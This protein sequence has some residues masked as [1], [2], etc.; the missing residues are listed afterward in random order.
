MKI[1]LIIFLLILHVNAFARLQATIITVS[2]TV[3]LA[4]TPEPIVATIIFSSNLFIQAK[5]A[6]TQ[7]AFVGP[8]SGSQNYELAPGAGLSL[9]EI[10]HLGSAID[11]DLNR[12]C[13]KV[14]VN[15]E[16]ANLLYTKIVSQ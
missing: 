10:T 14:S 15:G 7:S 16:G 1:I 2:K 4:A 3:T 8:C 12:I 6:N 11:I 13:L 5:S 9:A